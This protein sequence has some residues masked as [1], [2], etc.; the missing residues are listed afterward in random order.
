MDFGL[1]DRPR[2]DEQKIYK[3]NMLKIIILANMG[4]FKI[5]HYDVILP[6]IKKN[7]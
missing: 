7:F 5:T 4:G 1:N 3:Q 2:E 6:N